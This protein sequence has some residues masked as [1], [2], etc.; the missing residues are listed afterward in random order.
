MAKLMQ[1]QEPEG[2]IRSLEPSN[3]QLL[4]IIRGRRLIG[5]PIESFI[6][7]HWF[8]PSN[9]R[10]WS[11]TSQLLFQ[12]VLPHHPCQQ[13]GSNGWPTETNRPRRKSALPP[14]LD[15]SGTFGTLSGQWSDDLSSF[16]NHCLV[17]WNRY[18][19]ML[20]GW[21]VYSVL[22]P[23]NNEN[24]VLTLFGFFGLFFFQISSSSKARMSKSNITEG[25]K[26]TFATTWGPDW[27]NVY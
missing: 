7:C 25:Q 16:S 15:E 10:L 11:E 12:V 18:I 5:F 14:P 3:K 6:S 23:L 17:C 27:F 4:F 2:E 19:L 8:W 22:W 9:R 24:E 20:E 1:S 13:S 21:I 26:N